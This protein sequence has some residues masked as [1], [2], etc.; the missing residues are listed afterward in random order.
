MTLG[1]TSSRKAKI[2]V[3]RPFHYSPSAFQWSSGITQFSKHRH[4]QSQWPPSQAIHGAFQSRQGG[5]HSP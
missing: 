3:D 4:F 5:N 2:K 1:S